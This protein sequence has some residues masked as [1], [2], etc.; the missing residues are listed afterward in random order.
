MANKT[1]IRLFELPPDGESYFWDRKSGE[2]NTALEDLIGK[3]DYTVQFTLRPV[4]SRDFLMMG[5]IKTQAPETCSLCAMD[6]NLPIK[7]QINEILIPHQPQGRNSQ[8]ARVNHVSDANDQGPQSFEY[9]PSG[10]LDMASYV[11]E[12]IG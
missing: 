4:N 12:M 8:Y 2:L 9:D 11:H 1:K 6:F 5:S 3:Q 10:E 7:C